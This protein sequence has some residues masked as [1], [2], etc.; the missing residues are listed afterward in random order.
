MREWMFRTSVAAAAIVGLLFRAFSDK[1]ELV[2]A[3]HDGEYRFSVIGK[4]SSHGQP[5]PPPDCGYFSE[6]T[7]DAPAMRWVACPSGHAQHEWQDH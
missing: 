1:V 6:P 3:G 5:Q 2:R 4:R 7:K